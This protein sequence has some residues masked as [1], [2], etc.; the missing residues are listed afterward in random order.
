MTEE[1]KTFAA[2]AMMRAARNRISARIAGMTLEE[3]QRWLASQK[4]A[5]E[6]LRRLRDRAARGSDTAS[7]AEDHNRT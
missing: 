2:V 6:F 7:G 4:I 5:D 3:E 1:K